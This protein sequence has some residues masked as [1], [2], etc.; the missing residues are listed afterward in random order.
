MKVIKFIL[1]V[2]LGLGT[3]LI[4]NESDNILPNLI[5]MACFVT[6]LWLNRDMEEAK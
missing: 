6:L 2:V 5:G 1:N 4:L 3:W